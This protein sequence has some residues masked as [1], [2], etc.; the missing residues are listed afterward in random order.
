VAWRLRWL[1]RLHADV[2]L[3][4]TRLACIGTGVAE[5]GLAAVLF[6]SAQ[7][8]RVTQRLLC[9]ASRLLARASL[10]VTRCQRV[11]TAIGSVSAGISLAL[12]VMKLLGE[13]VV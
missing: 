2:L 4:V 11:V 3:I 10:V 1:Q 6:D 12:A 8:R 13:R 5:G 7:V 9:C